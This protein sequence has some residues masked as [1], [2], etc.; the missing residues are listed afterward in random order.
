M[1]KKRILC[2]EDLKKLLKNL[3]INVDIIS[4]TIINNKVK[5]IYIDKKKY[6]FFNLSVEKR[7]I[8]KKLEK[9]YCYGWQCK[10]IYDKKKDILSICLL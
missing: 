5:K 7:K 9:F 8:N 3:N 10:F 1:L 4:G 2:E 6:P